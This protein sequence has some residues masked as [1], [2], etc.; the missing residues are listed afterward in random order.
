MIVASEL[1]NAGTQ[2]L[3]PPVVCS[4]PRQEQ[5]SP[6]LGRPFCLTRCRT[7][8]VIEHCMQWG[9]EQRLR[10]KVTLDTAGGCCPWRSNCRLPV[11]TVLAGAASLDLP[12]RGGVATTTACGQRERP[13]PGAATGAPPDPACPRPAGGSDGTELEVLPLRVAV[14]REAWEGLPGSFTPDVQ[15]AGAAEQQEAS[16]R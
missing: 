5:A 9:G 14:S 1:A 15:G 12:A 7:A 11:Q 16:R 8:V 4:R 10:I 3:L 13:S 2:C 6:C